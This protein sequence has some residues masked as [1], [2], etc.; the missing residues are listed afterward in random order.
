MH[1]LYSGLC[2]NVVRSSTAFLN[3]LSR[4]CLCKVGFFRKLQS[5][6]QD[7]LIQT[8]AKAYSDQKA[9]LD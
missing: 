9:F 4:K 8:H 6:W 3:Q 2:L 1:Y 7:K 5:A